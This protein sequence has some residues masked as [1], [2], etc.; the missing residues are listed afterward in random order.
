MYPD[1]EPENLVANHNKYIQDAL[2][3]LQTKVPCLQG[4]HRDNHTAESSYFD[5]G[6][7]VYDA[8]VGFIKGVHTILDNDCC[9]RVYYDPITED[10]MRCRMET[11]QTCGVR[12][13]AYGFYEYASGA[14]L[15]YAYHY[16]CQIYPDAGLDKPCRAAAGSVALIDGQL[17]LHPHLQSDEIAVIEWEGIKKS[18]A[19]TDEVDFGTFQRQVENAVEL[20]LERTASRK[21]DFDP[22][23]TEGA[24]ADYDGAVAMMI[25]EC[26][27]LN[28]IQ[29][30][31]FCFNNC[32]RC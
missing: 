12:Y 26:N 1:G 20:Y 18:W 15:P 23:T 31:A 29:P 16:E 10:N 3:D 11:Q 24:Q 7:S 30:R 5:C 28:R 25:Y 13:R 2:I 21:E 9:A 19:S 6:T 14:Y 17:Y 22:Q 4:F 32:A 8:P 27:K